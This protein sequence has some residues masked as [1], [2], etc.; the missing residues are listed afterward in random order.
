MKAGKA[1]SRQ[2][3]LVCRMPPS[4]Q[5]QGRRASF[6]RKRVSYYYTGQ[7]PRA[8]AVARRRAGATEYAGQ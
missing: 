2:S 7:E 5:G 6:L 8:E 3:K 4:E 1:G